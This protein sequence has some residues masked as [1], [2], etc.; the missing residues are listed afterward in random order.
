[1]IQH[2][3]AAA[4]GAAAIPVAVSAEPAVAAPR[5]SVSGELG[6]V[7]DYRFR[8]LSLS[9]RRPALQGGLTLE[10]DSGLYGSVWASNIAESEGGAHVEVD[11]VAGYAAELPAGFAVDLSVSYYGYPSDSGIGYAEASATVSRTFGPATPKL[12]IAYA[13]RQRAMRDALGARHDNAYF[14]TGLDLAVPGLPLTLDAQLGYERGW[15]DGADVGG[16]L[17]WQLGGTFV[18]RGL[19]L[20]LHY[21][22]SNATYIDGRGRDLAAA[23]VIA[24]VNLAF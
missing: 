3:L 13:P 9:S 10:H 2:L 7:S 17:D 8:G 15:F 21:V 23:T 20:G 16:K 19:D 5:L 11:L 12:G 22:D 4:V 24:S 1:M 6:V 14:F 18:F